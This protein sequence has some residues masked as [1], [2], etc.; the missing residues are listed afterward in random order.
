MGTGLTAAA[1][2]DTSAP[3]SKAGWIFGGVMAVA[4]LGGAGF[5]FTR[6]QP[7]PESTPSETPAAS[8]TSSTSASVVPVAAGC[9]DQMI[10]LKGGS[11]FMGSDDTDLADDVRPAHQVKVSTFCI[12]KNEVTTGAYEACVKSGNCKRPTPGVSFPGETKEAVAAFSPLCNYEQP[13]KANHPMNCLTWDMAKQFC[14]TEKGRLPEGGALLP[15]E[16]EWEFAARGSG[17]R[18]YPWGDDEPGPKHLNACGAECSAWLASVKMGSSDQMF[19][20]DDGFAATAP[21]GSFPAGASSAGI[22]DLAGNVWEWTDDWYGPYTTDVAS[23]PTGPASGE[24]RSVRGGGFNGQQP[25]WAKPA[26]RWHTK[27][28]SRSHGIGFRCALSAP[29]ASAPSE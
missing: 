19:D 29:S 2:M 4:L 22:L 28:E 10:E 1:S 21:V 27:P 13:G 18:Q 3:S 23:D 9:P 25:S 15:T 6:M 8:P 17:Q 16:A 7:P 20:G 12:D 11:M 5:Y 24:D 26:F 14:Q